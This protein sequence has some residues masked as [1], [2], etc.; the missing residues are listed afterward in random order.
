MNSPKV[1]SRGFT[2]VEVLVV[3]AIIAVLAAILFPVFISAK[4]SAYSASCLSNIR[5]LSSAEKLY[6]SD[7]DD[8]FVPVEYSVGDSRIANK[9]GSADS[10]FGNQTW[11]QL[12][13]PYTPTFY[14]FVCPADPSELSRSNGVFDQ[15]IVPG[16]LS[17][18]AFDAS[19]HSDYAYNYMTFSPV[20]RNQNSWMVV[21]RAESE[22]EDPS[23]TMMFID[24]S[25]QILN[26]VD[27]GTGSWVVEPPCRFYRTGYQYID[28][29][30]ADG[31]SFENIFSF[32]TGWTSGDGRPYGGASLRHL[33]HSNVVNA[34]GSARGQTKSQLLRGCVVEDSWAGTVSTP[35]EYSWTAKH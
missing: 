34:D 28:L 35:Q 23:E 20:V 17:A 31:S 12:L 30:A 7:Y 27:Q 9:F 6:S 18:R 33:N 19:K 29:F 10:Y 14:S 24:S 2:L 21:P 8:R 3:V 13:L 15:D 16:D 5:N 22:I 26:G 1:L 11:V 4:Q 25:N 32:F